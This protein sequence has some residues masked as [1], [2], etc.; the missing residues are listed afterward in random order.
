MATTR[1]PALAQN[2]AQPTGKDKEVHGKDDAHTKDGHK[3]DG[4]K[5]AAA[6]DGA[7]MRRPFWR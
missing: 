2:A 3:H 7:V 6:G 5:K 1:M 4:E